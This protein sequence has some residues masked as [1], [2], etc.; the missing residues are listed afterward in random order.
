MNRCDGI[1]KG[2]KR[3]ISVIPAKAGIQSRSE[4]DFKHL[5]ILWTPVSTGV[6][7]FYDSIRCE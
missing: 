4:R 1:V 3:R 2:L 5:K 7:D 6:N